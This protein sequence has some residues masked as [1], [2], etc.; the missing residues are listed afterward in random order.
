MNAENIRAS[1]ESLLATGRSSMAVEK[2]D[3]QM[4]SPPSA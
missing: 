2:L 4:N 1:F 3:T